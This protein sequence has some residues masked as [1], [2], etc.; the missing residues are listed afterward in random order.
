[1]T[2]VN[3]FYD[4]SKCDINAT[5]NLTSKPQGP[6]GFV[7][8]VFTDNIKTLC[9]VLESLRDDY[10]EHV[11]SISTASLSTKPNESQFSL[12]RGRILTPDPFQFGEIF[13]KVVT[14]HVLKSSSSTNFLYVLNPTRTYYE[15][16]QQRLIDI[17]VPS[18]PSRVP[19]PK[20][21]AS[22]IRLLRDYKIKY[23]QGVRQNSIHNSNTKNKAGTLPVEAYAKSDPEP[24]EINFS[25]ILLGTAPISRPEE[26]TLTG[27]Q[28]LFTKGSQLLVKP[29]ETS[30]S[31][32]I[33]AKTISDIIENCDVFTALVYS[34]DT[35]DVLNLNHSGEKE[36]I[37]FSRIVKEVQPDSTTELSDFE[38]DLYLGFLASPT[39]VSI[40]S[41]DEQIEESLQHLMTLMIYPKP[42]K[43][44]HPEAA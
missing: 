44:H 20:L 5:Y 21:S 40:L 17:E 8:S 13:P 25:D 16:C 31:K 32:I 4:K 3:K 1:M 42:P 10:P 18:L 30:D 36:T 27:P 26:S 19:G 39:T 43:E 28:V 9:E 22:D 29:T 41:E 33:I 6:Q 34:N 15:E 2:E 38:Y 24:K 37:S 7:S 14:Q 35:L 12:T 23:F 11:D